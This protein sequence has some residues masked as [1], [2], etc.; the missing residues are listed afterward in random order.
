MADVEF[1][2]KSL[3]DALTTNA[4]VICVHYACE[5]LGKAKNRPPK[6]SC[7]A[8][9]DIA[10]D[11]V[12]V[13]SHRNFARDDTQTIREN[14]GG[15]FWK[16]ISERRPAS[17]PAPELQVLEAFYDLLQHHPEAQVVHWNMNSASFGFDAIGDRYYSL[18]GKKPPYSI[19]SHRLHDLDAMLGKRYGA[20][21]ASHP[22]LKSTAE[23]N[24]CS[25]RSFL[26]GVDEAAAFERGDFAVIEAS[27]RAKVDII[28]TLLRAACNGSLRTLTSVGTTQF[29]GEHL[30]AVEVVLELG[31][32]FGDIGRALRNR[33]DNRSTLELSDEYD[34]QDLLRALLRLFFSDVRDEVWTPNYAGGS[35]KIDF[36]LHDFDLAI[37]LKYT[38]PGLNAR[39]VADQLIVDRDRYK[40][41][42]QAKH[43][44]CLVFDYGHHLQNPRGLEKD[45]S[46]E[47]SAEGIAVTVRIYTD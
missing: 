7:I 37:E 40:Q 44:V 5:D 26:L 8:V 2:F 11:E 35:A 28:A 23:L 19:P 13:V 47:T 9:R 1:E 46:K 15:L 14:T 6:V 34:A 18:T 22:K 27:T 38:R 4:D 30:E 36:W 29:A 16:R 25:M 42:R 39:N 24:A 20:E 43:L 33:H 45:L 21:Y 32:H 17:E 41:H 31:G 12:R 3:R 10:G